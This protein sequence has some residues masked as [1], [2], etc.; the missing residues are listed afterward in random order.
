MT[1]PTYSGMQQSVA[2]FA[3][4]AKAVLGRVDVLNVQDGGGSG[5]IAP[6][7]ITNWFG[8]LANVFGSV[9]AGFLG[10]LLGALAAHLILG[11]R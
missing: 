5:Y 11:R 6:S 3:T 7:D 8:A 1:S 4:S 10:V 2:Q 9:A